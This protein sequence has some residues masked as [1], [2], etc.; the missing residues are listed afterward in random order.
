MT[1]TPSNLLFEVRP[2]EERRAADDTH[3]ALIADVIVA[4]VLGRP[5]RAPYTW[6]TNPAG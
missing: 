5:A 6:R 1:M 4:A 3:P 2:F